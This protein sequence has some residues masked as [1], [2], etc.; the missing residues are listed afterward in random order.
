MIEY[1]IENHTHDEKG[2][3][4]LKRCIEIIFSK[5]NLYRMMKPD[6]M[7]FGDK[8][9]ENIKFPFELSTDVIDTLIKK[10]KEH[11][12]ALPMYI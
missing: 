10:N 4:N 9:I 8:I 5:L 7:L 11:S 6:T 1:I 3:R 12:S 2:V